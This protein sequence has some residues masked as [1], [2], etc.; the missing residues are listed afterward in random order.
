MNLIET[1]VVIIG[2]VG[3]GKSTQGALVAEAIN[4]Q[5]LSLDTIANDYY[6]ANGFSMAYYQKAKK[7]QGLLEAYRQWWPSLA[8]AA[9]Q[10]VNDYPGHVIDFG[11][12]HSHY[13]DEK[14]FE[15][16][17]LALS[18]ILNVILLLPSPDLDHSVTVLRERC[19]KQ[20]GRDWIANGYDF[21]EHWVK[22]E[23]NHRLATMTIYTEGKTS[24]ETR[25]EIV[26]KL[27]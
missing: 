23:C 14:L 6:E 26:H 15:G 5:S 3:V 2:P 13:D 4:K 9:Q 11:A 12:G 24:E 22:D 20:R 10:V 21:I 25:N 8:Y 16:V 1:G 19:T 7:E 17:E 18:D 27:K